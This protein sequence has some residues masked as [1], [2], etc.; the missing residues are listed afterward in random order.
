M[1]PDEVNE[2]RDQAAIIGI[3]L[4]Q[5]VEDGQPG[6]T[7]QDNV[8]KWIDQAVIVGMGNCVRCLETASIKE[9]AR[10]GINSGIYDCLVEARRVLADR[11]GGDAALLMSNVLA[12][13]IRRMQIRRD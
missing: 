1:T 8:N 10:S 7:S 5:P 4:P 11:G 13:A 3:Q 9:P 2:W 12:N 6:A